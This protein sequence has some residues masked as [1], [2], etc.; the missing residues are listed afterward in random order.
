MAA[1]KPKGLRMGLPRRVSELQHTVEKQVRRTFARATDLLP[2]TP[3]K[4]VKRMVADA[5][6]RGEH[7]RKRGDKAVADVRKRVERWTTDVEKRFKEA[8]APVTA[9]LDVASRADVDRLRK[10]LEHIEHRLE[11]HSGHSG[12]PA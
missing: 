3:R 1:K 10:R 9:R 11:T 6:R 7:L 4:A 2:P 12:A 5:E 8:V